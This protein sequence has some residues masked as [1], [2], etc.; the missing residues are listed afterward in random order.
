MPSSF[1][2]LSDYI[3]SYFKWLSR[4]GQFNPDD[5]DEIFLAEAISYLLITNNILPY[6]LDYKPI[7]TL[8]FLIKVAEKLE[9]TSMTREEWQPA[10]AESPMILM[11]HLG[12]IDAT[13]AEAYNKKLEDVH[14]P[15]KWLSSS[16]QAEYQLAFM[17]EKQKNGPA[18]EVE[19]AL[20]VE[21]ALNDVLI[22]M[23]EGEEDSDKI[24]ALITRVFNAYAYQLLDI[25]RLTDIYYHVSD[26]QNFAR[27]LLQVYQDAYN[28]FKRAQHIQRNQFLLGFNHL[29]AFLE[30]QLSYSNVCALLNETSFS[31]EDPSKM[32]NN[33]EYRFF[34]FSRDIYLGK[35][36]D[37]D[38][39]CFDD[40][41]SMTRIASV[42]FHG[43]LREIGVEKVKESLS[44]P[45]PLLIQY[46]INQQSAEVKA[47]FETFYDKFL[48]VNAQAHPK[49]QRE[50][51]L[52]FM[53]HQAT[54]A[55]SIHLMGL[56][57]IKKLTQQL[58]TTVLSLERYCDNLPIVR[59]DFLAP[60]K[61]FFMS[62]Q[63]MIQQSPQEKDACHRIPLLLSLLTEMKIKIFYSDSDLSDDMSE[64]SEE[65]RTAEDEW[66]A[67]MKDKSPSQYMKYLANQ[68]LS[69]MLEGFKAPT[70]G[71]DFDVIFNR[72]PLEKFTQLMEASLHMQ[73]SAYRDVFNHL[74]YLDLTAGDVNRFLHDETQEEPLGQELARHN[75]RIH[76][77]LMA[78]HIDP[79]MAFNYSKTKDIVI[80]PT[81][82]ENSQHIN[83]LYTLWSYLNSLQAPLEAEIAKLTASG[84]ELQE[85]DKKVL[86]QLKAIKRQHEMLAEKMR[87]EESAYGLMNE[88]SKSA[89]N[90]VNKNLEALAIFQRST[91]RF[92]VGFIEFL[93]HYR[94]QYNFIN[95]RFDDCSSK[96]TKSPK[97]QSFRFLQ[98]SK[99]DP[100]TSFLGD[101]V[102][103]CLASTSSQFSALVQRRMD[104]AMLF[105]VAV[106]MKTKKPAALIWLFLAENTDGKIV[107]VANFFEVNTRY[108]L[109]NTTRKALL[110]GLLEFTRE[111]CK[112]NPSIEGFYMNQ[113]TYGWNTHDL[114]GYPLQEL[115][116]KDKLGGPFIPDEIIPDTIGYEEVRGA[117]AQHYYLASLAKGHTTFHRFDDSVLEK[118]QLPNVYS[119]E[120]ILIEAKRA[121]CAQVERMPS[122][123][124]FKEAVIQHYRLELAPFFTEPLDGSCAFEARLK[125]IYDASVVEEEPKAAKAC[126]A[127]TLSASMLFKPKGDNDSSS[128]CPE[129]DLPAYRPK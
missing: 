19:T 123:N 63:A 42:L 127:G 79:S 64:C 14:V 13:M 5:Q 126:S 99:N 66:I 106:D 58:A 25:D 100:M 4:C 35:D 24:N 67:A 31:L 87:K 81:G 37:L 38:R 112:D 15:V 105:H 119:L 121:L 36:V 115:L 104:D 125:A 61:A 29:T 56:E 113:L 44:S 110:N 2:K 102:G 98:W 75:K 47:A 85:M 103:C 49:Q 6:A 41:L 59:N 76:E 10:L 3:G 39:R 50:A 22:K 11:Q 97:A 43:W 34:I 23:K 107:L 54:I 108:A 26:K 28:G 90:K 32:E 91:S 8:D 111:Y 78:H 92:D 48:K 109:D 117:T 122:F 101:E 89:F 45:L 128:S 73:A 116:L 9:R 40:A 82:K 17:P 27:I 118:E 21:A 62:H 74:I 96:K 33:E 30:K 18:A 83:A 46:E 65:N 88:A 69:M 124:A 20:E 84:K 60:L 120:D 57:A 129:E 1:E 94:E 114:V 77:K 72:I 55:Q 80:Y 52:F 7:Q 51:H 53:H 70:E 68:L 86:S 71:I 12:Q 95:H 16:Q 93:E